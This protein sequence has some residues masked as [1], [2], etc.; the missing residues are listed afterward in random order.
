MDA[1]FD[2]ARGPG[3]RFG[4]VV[5]AVA[6]VALASAV[7]AI[8]GHEPSLVPS[9]TGCLTNGGTIADIQPGDVPRKAC[10]QQ[11]HFSGGDITAVS[12]GTG[13]SG[14]GDEGAVTLSV[15]AS[16][17]DPSTVQRRVTGSC[18]VGQAIAQINQ[19]GTVACS[20]GPQVFL[21]APGGGDVPNDAATIGSLPLPAGKYLITAKLAVRPTHIGDETDDYWDVNCTLAAGGDTDEAS[22]SDDTSEDFHFGRS[23]TLNMIVTHEFAG[24]GSATVD[25]HDD[26]D[27]SGPS[28]LSFMSLVIAAIRV[29]DIQLP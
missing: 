23:G 9:Y 5:G 19:D 17:I 10:D 3:W 16:A 24:P 20:T 21:R 22:E 15:D 13:L 4:A 11:I 12:A 1:R 2:G 26:G 28:D 8:A 27:A 25:C 18:T 7:Y 29:G 6:V 14:G